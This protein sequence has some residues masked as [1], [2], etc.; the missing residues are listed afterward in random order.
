MTPRTHSVTHAVT[1]TVTPSSPAA[2]AASGPGRAPGS[3]VRARRP[4][5]ARHRVRGGRTAAHARMVARRRAA[6]LFERPGTSTTHPP[7]GGDAPSPPA[8]GGASPALGRVVVAAPAPLRPG[9]PVAQAPLAGGSPALPPPVVGDPQTPVGTP[10]PQAEAGAGV[11]AEGAGPGGGTGLERRDRWRLGVRDRLP[12]WVQTRCG[13]EPRTVVALVIVLVVAVTLAG[14]YF[15][16][17]RP[18]A[19][20]APDVVTGAASAPAAA[21]SRRPPAG[22]PPVVVDVSGTVRRPGVLRLPAGSRVA[23]ALRA[24]GGVRPG[25]DVTG[26]NRA[27]VLMDGEHIVVGA[28]PAP[29]GPVTGAPGA[30]VV[31][32]VPAGPVSLNTA[33]V[34]QLDTLPGV[35]P[36]LAQHIVDHRTRHG[37]F[38]SVDE[39]REVNGIGERRF[40]DL[41]PL[42]RP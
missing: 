16:T 23:D 9:R 32:G 6:A 2:R 15:W 22:T 18:E 3:D 17:G 4:G 38:R 1:H 28:A 41:Q 36:V 42:V 7:P 13:M 39:L 24:A 25:S 35:G 27:R 11:A 31:G 19:V 37:G 21:A 40:A 14:R 29:P 33:T 34:E 12:L 5:S 8:A 20:R 26:L 10:V 30:A